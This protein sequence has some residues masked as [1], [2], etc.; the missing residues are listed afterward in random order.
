MTIEN[1]ASQLCNMPKK[2]ITKL[3]KK[4]TVLYFLSNEVRGLNVLHLLAWLDGAE[5]A[6]L[7]IANAYPELLL[8]TYG[9]HNSTPLHIAATCPF[10]SKKNVKAIMK[11]AKKHGLSPMKL[12]RSKNEI[13]TPAKEAFEHG[14]IKIYNYLSKKERKILQ[15]K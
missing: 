12:L 15:S 10:D 2:E 3:V 13:G 14:N 6:I 5:N 7:V 11:C 1:L 9:H 8:M 4:H